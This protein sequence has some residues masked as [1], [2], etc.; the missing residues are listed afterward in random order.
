MKA[1]PA[2]APF[3]VLRG[4]IFGDENH[5]RSPSDKLIVFG[6]RLRRHQRKHSSAVRRPDGYPTL[7]GLKLGIEGH[8]EAELI[9]VEPQAFILI[10]NVNLNGVD[11]EM[12]AVSV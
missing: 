6:A 4:Y 5:S 10:A 7:A 12:G 11:L 1:H 3:T 2:P 8:L 9:Y